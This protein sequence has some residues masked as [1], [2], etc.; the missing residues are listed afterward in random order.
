M[1]GENMQE[2]FS[3]VPSSEINSDPP[4][5]KNKRGIT[6]CNAV[7]LATQDGKKLEV[8]F[9][10][11]GTEAVGKNARHLVSFCGVLIKKHAKLSATNW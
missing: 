11:T 1:E 2:E 3:F 7:V 8:Y 4:K 10:N 6:T 9:P 5:V